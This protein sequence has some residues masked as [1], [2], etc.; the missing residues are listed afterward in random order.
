MNLTELER[1]ARGVQDF[2]GKG[3]FHESAFDDFGETTKEYL[4]AIEP[5]DVLE[6]ISALKTAKEALEVCKKYEPFWNTKVKTALQACS[7][8]DKNPLW[9]SPATD[10]LGT[11][12]SVCGK[13]EV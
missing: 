6:L 4:L 8:A 7:L 5:S 2:R 3:W 9:I 10:A 13:E 12:S 1:L 11:L